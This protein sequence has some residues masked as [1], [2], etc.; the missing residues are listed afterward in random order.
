MTTKNEYHQFD[1]NQLAV[2]AFLKNIK[3]YSPENFDYLIFYGA[4]ARGM[5]KFMEYPEKFGD[6]D[7]G[8][9]CSLFRAIDKTFQHYVIE[10]PEIPAQTEEDRI[11]SSIL[12]VAED[13]FLS[14]YTNNRLFNKAHFI[15]YLKRE[16]VIYNW[17]GWLMSCIQSE[18][19]EM[20]KEMQMRLGI[21]G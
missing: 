10:C 7:F 11:L 16:D 2:L 12:I 17:N 18:V 8:F 5:I 4:S 19:E 13:S 3:M 20:K 14:A 1:D 6:F 9:V 15:S 21:V